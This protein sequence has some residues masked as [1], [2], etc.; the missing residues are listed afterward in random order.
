MDGGAGQH[1]YGDEPERI[2]VVDG[3]GKWTAV[4]LSV[5]G[6]SSMSMKLRVEGPVISYQLSVISHQ[7]SVI[8]RGVKRETGVVKR[9]A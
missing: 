1:E 4:V 5:G 7:S 2:V 8:R 6:G 3:D 9:K